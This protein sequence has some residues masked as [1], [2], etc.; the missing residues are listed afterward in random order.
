MA[1]TATIYNL[2]IQLSD[3]DRGIYEPLALRLAR[4]PSETAEYLLTRALAYCLEWTEGLAFSRG[5]AEPDEPT[6]AVRDLTGAL[7]TWIDVGSPDAARIHKASKAAARV[8]IYTHKDPAPLLQKLAGER[9]HRAEAIEI[10]GFD[11]ELIAELASRLD[12]RLAFDLAVSDRHLWVTCGDVT[13][14]GA[15]A[16]YRLAPA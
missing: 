8:A 9:I 2:E 3:T 10:Y 13:L 14:S 16:P 12:R 11:R 5:L 6:L 7:Q 4:Q 1:L 15:V